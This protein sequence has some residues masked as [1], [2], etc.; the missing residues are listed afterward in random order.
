MFQDNIY[1][2]FKLYIEGVQVPFINIAI[3]QSLGGFPSASISIPPMSGLMDI[4]RFYQPKVHVFFTERSYTPG[5]VANPNDTVGGLA[6]KGDNYTTTDKVIFTGYITTSHYGKT[7]EGNDG[8]ASITFDCIHRYNLLTEVQLDYCGFIRQGDL[9][10]S[11]SQGFSTSMNSNSAMMEALNGWNTVNTPAQDYSTTNPTG[12]NQAMDRLPSY[13]TDFQYRLKG[14]VGVFINFWN[15]L[16]NASYNKSLAAAQKSFTGVYEPLIENGLNFFKRLTGHMVIEQAIDNSRQSGCGPK[17]DKNLLVPPCHKLFFASGVQASLT[18]NTLGQYLQSSNEITDI[19][20][21]FSMYYQTLDYDIVTLA[22][23]AEVVMQPNDITLNQTVVGTNNTY[24]VDTI[25]KPS[26]PFYFTPMCNILLPSMYTQVNVTYDEASLPTRLDIKNTE[27]A[28]EGSFGLHYR[29]PPSIRQAIASK[30]NTNLVGTLQGSY[31]AIGPYELGRGIKAEVLAM[32]SWFSIFSAAQANSGLV[33]QS[34]VPQSSDYTNA[35]AALKQGWD[36]RYPNQEK[37]NPWSSDSGLQPYQQL[38]ISTADYFYVKRFSGT[39]MGSVDCLFNPYII[40]GYAM[41]IMEANPNLPS[42]HAMCTAVSHNISASSVSTSVQFAGAMTYTEL[43]NY[44]IPFV[45]P[46]LQVQ[47]GLAASPTLVGSDP[48]AITTAN[49]FYRP[50]LGVNAVTPE[51]LYDFSTGATKSVKMNGGAVV[52]DDRLWEEHS[53]EEDM[54]TICSRPI[55]SKDDFAARHQ[56][57]F[58]DL[59]PS[60]YMATGLKY[61]DPK[62]T[63][64]S[65]ARFEIGESQFL[66]Y[67]AARYKQVSGNII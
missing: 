60:N 39:K 34:L 35:V 29:T 59:N 66:D 57:S 61:M 55:E 56:I 7:K 33:H 49:Q 54:M 46:Y 31:G 38:L 27:T 5:R 22:C 40:P 52:Q 42:F 21:V 18:Y 64:N 51:M 16:K 4:A 53:F 8:S 15:Q 9:T 48:A 23:P 12:V 47:L 2:S 37:L 19:Y 10:G 26:L 44:Y 45:N 63:D 58:I 32:P 41:D 30:L 20:T 6:I 3:N 67:P 13:L 43:V 62:L 65:A 17:G 36:L 24:A 14:M 28:T 50:T 11:P 1:Q 25:V